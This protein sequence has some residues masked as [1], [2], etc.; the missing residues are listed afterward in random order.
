[1]KYVIIAVLL[2]LAAVALFL[3][4]RTEYVLKKFFKKE[5]PQ[6]QEVLRVKLAALVIGVIV[7][8]LAITCL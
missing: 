6:E 1:M 7:F 4:Y 5:A 8:I 3:T 2:L